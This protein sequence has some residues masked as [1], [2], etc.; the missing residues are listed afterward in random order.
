MTKQ[1]TLQEAEDLLEKRFTGRYCSFEYPGYDTVY[2][3]VDRI[4]IQN[5]DE[6]LVVILM[7][8]KRYTV[9]PESLNDCLTLLKK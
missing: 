7:N 9:S 3:M 1:I 4:S 2:G 8:D 5:I 6:P